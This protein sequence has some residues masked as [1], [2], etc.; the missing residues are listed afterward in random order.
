ML[1]KGQIKKGFNLINN[2]IKNKE[3]F[4]ADCKSCD[5]FYADR[6]KKE[7]Y[8]HHNGVTKF[9]M[10]QVNERTYCIYWISN[11]SKRDM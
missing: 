6:G 5:Y 9:D 11:K 2:H 10:C 7:E 1:E 3:A 8:C 4:I